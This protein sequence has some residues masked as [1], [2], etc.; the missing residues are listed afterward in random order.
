M[1]NPGK[2]AESC[3]TSQSAVMISRRQ[4]TKLLGVGILMTITCSDTD[5]GQTA[6]ARAR[7]PISD[8]LHVSVDG[9]I[10]IMTGKVDIGQG[11]RTE[12]TLVAAEELKV[13][14]AG[15]RLIMGDTALCP[16]DGSTGSSLTTPRTV[17]RVRAACAAAREILIKMAAKHWECDPGLLKARDST[18]VHT[19]DGQSISYGEL[20]R[21]GGID[22]AM[23]K[24]DEDDNAITPVAEWTVMGY[25]VRR[26]TSKEIVTGAQVF[27]SDIRRPDMQYGKVLN[28]PAYGAKLKVIDLQPAK[29]IAGV[30]A[31]RDG[32]FVGVTAPTSHLA[33]LAVNRIARTAKWETFTQPSSSELFTY[34]RE[35][36]S[37]RH[38][39]QGKVVQKI[40]TL[41][42]G[43]DNAAQ[44]L[45][46]SYTLAHIQHAP[47][48]PRAAVAKWSNGN[49]TVWA[50]TADPFPVRRTLSKELGISTERIRV[51]VP[52][53]GGHFCGKHTGEAAIQAAK[54]ARVARKPVHIRWTR[55]EEFTWA[56]FRKAGIIDVRAGIDASGQITAWDW[57]TWHSGNSAITVPYDI[58]NI[59]VQSKT[60][61]APVREGSY[62]A[63]AAPANLFARESFMDEL[64]HAAKTD[65]IEF[66]LQ[67]ISNERLRAVV[68]AAAQRFGWDK[69][70]RNTADKRGVGIACGTEKGSYVAT[71]AEVDVDRE[72][73]EIHVVRV[74]EAFECGAII[75]PANLKI[76]VEGCIVMGMG[77]ALWEEIRFDNG[78]ILNAGF[79]RYRVPRF[80]DLPELDVILMDRPDLPSTGAG[81][82]PMIAIAPAIANAV[83]AATGVRIRSMPMK[84]EYLK[85]G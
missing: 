24:A 75:N 70:R 31:M 26:L 1:S 25:P 9:T 6:K 49:V 45:T 51:I 14:I 15:V 59:F 36:V 22:E 28:P 18:V 42:A 8:R 47:M 32:D 81:E 27:P 33:E 84:G 17:P 69:A 67:H 3:N 37:D 74:C 83:F 66:R 82:T 46:E 20:A 54:L 41:Q 80:S 11:S 2:D 63:V 12:L 38:A 16:D 72:Q 68:D 43:L 62:R 77:G 71:C 44:V 78:R 19:T 5:A 23:E 53:T 29:D 10:T 79:D 60:C 58:P 61:R 4:F 40:G 35:H 65:P 55:E 39:K 64:A 85:N 73:G 7:S 30:T 48:E 56:Y 34:I 76:Q 57:T 21:I 52:D 13:D 50:G